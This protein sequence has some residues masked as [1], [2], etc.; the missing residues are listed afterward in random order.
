M[1]RSFGKHPGTPEPLHDLLHQVFTVRGENTF[2]MEE[3]VVSTKPDD[4]RSVKRKAIVETK[5]Q[6]QKK[7]KRENHKKPGF[8]GKLL[9]ETTCF[10]RNGLRHVHPYYFSFTTHC[11]GRWVGRTLIDVFKEEFQSETQEYYEKAISAGKITVNGDVASQGTILK[12]NDVICNRVHRH[13]PPVAGNTL[14]IVELT[15]ELVVLNK[16]SSIPVH[17]C[18]RYRHN[19]VV[20]ILGKEHGL[21]NL[22]TIHRIDRLTSGVLMFARTLAKAQELES[23]VRNREIEKEYICRV[24]GEFPSETVDCEE[25]VLVVSH[26]IGVCRV[27]QN[28][29]PCKTVFTRIGCNG[30]T[31]VVKCVPYTGRMHQI[32]VHLQ[33]LGYP[34]VNDPIY[35]HIS[36][37]PNRGRGGVSEEL[38]HK[39]IGEMAKS[40]T[41]TGFVA[42]DSDGVDKVQPHDTTNTVKETA[43][44]TH[45]NDEKMSL[46]SQ[47][48][49][50]QYYD[51]G[52]SECHV[53]RRDPTPSELTMY[54]HALSYKGPTW[55][56]RTEVPLWAEE[57][58]SRQDT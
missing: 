13:E 38:V 9:E 4:K 29:K 2:N 35:N 7:P 5:K 30:Q 23:Q 15:D 50:D 22:F 54:L 17:P 27:A 45:S 55:E 56:Y 32:R 14:Q 34:I 20:F 49:S 16:P 1:Q 57:E 12:D 53:N 11:K 6:H 36:W 41:I 47:S 26:K 18:G 46:G 42:R 37:G 33:W 21:T 19:T 24:Q 8:D 43:E 31:S 10:I 25:P 44:S 40:S 52:C 51:K 28:G 58:W 48:C 39:V 3:P